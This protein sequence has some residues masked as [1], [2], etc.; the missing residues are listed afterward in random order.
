MRH[1]ENSDAQPAAGEAVATSQNL[2]GNWG[3]L[4][5]LPGHP[6]MWILI[7]SEILAFGAALIG[8]SG[9]RRA[10]PELFAAGQAGLD[11]VAGAVNT[12]VLMTSG[13]FAA[14]AVEARV[15]NRLGETRG[16]LMAAQALGVVFLVVKGIEYRH[17]FALGY[18]FDSDT[19]HTLYFLITGFHAAHVVAGILILSLVMKRTSLQAVETGTAFW[20]MVDLVWV[21]V[22][23]VVYLMR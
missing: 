22:F 1:T 7:V 12:A 18:G 5:D 8:F 2:E 9:A 21:L 16:W 17:E 15:H 14:L 6:M 13:L 11:Q 19:F 23:P 4:S 20:H 10:G 3:P